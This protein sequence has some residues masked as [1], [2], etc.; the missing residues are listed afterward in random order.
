MKHPLRGKPHIVAGRDGAPVCGPFAQWIVYLYYVRV[1]MDRRVAGF[2]RSVR[3]LLLVVEVWVSPRQPQAAPGAPSTPRDDQAQ[4]GT[5]RHTQAHEGT[6]P[7]TPF[8]L[9]APM[10]VKS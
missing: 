6:L 9:D 5:L 8:F 4:P 7:G 1:S 2:S 3:V 10:I